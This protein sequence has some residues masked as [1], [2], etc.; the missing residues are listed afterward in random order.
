MI[1]STACLK[2]YNIII[3]MFALE[4]YFIVFS[5][6]TF[7]NVAH[8]SGV[9]NLLSCR[10][11]LIQANVI[12]RDSGVHSSYCEP[13]GSY[14][15]KVICRILWVWVSALV[16]WLLCSSHLRW[17]TWM[18]TS[19]GLLSSPLA[20][21]CSGKDQTGLFEL[22]ALCLVTLHAPEAFL[23]GA[24]NWVNIVQYSL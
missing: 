21:S 9:N 6:A 4:L 20:S 10:W 7:E 23:F 12:R 16:I 2:R 22:W 5:V 8:L 19:E 15:M 14:I 13:K 1:F 18:M 24:S 17:V 3:Y 11:H